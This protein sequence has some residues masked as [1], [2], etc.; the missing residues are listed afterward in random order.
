MPRMP[1]TFRPATSA[2]AAAVVALWREAAAE[3]SRTDDVESVRRLIA[4]DPA[5]L[6]LVEVDDK[7]VGSV[8]A[9]WDGWR[10]SIHRLVVVPSRRRRGLGRRLVQQAEA[11][12]AEAG[13][14]RSQAIVVE[15]D[16]R[17]VDF[18]RSSGWEQQTE[19][20]RFVTG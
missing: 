2:D 7:L 4:R 5:A 18:W 11:R 20:L 15:T 13:A 8:I 16:Q 9:G 1:P 19:R 6:I 17:A 14:V 12:L 3:P 10:G